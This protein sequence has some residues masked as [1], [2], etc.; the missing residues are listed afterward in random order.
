MKFTERGPA[1][2]FPLPG[3]HKFGPK[4]LVSDIRF[5]D[6]AGQPADQ[7]TFWEYQQEVRR[8]WFPDFRPN[9]MFDGDTQRAVVEIQRVSGLSLTGVVDADTWAA[10]FT[11]SVAEEATFERGS[12]L[13]APEMEGVNNTRPQTALGSTESDEN[14]EGVPQGTLEEEAPQ[15]PSETVPVSAKRGRGRP[16]LNTPTRIVDVAA[17]A[18]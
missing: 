3:G 9:G 5:H 4:A 8:R 2:R 7:L 18:L 16:R 10:T 6:P 1:P 11:R 13:T 17:A 15:K 12:T 14:Q